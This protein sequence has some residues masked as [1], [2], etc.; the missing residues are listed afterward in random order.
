MKKKFKEILEKED[1]NK[2][3]KA[4]GF[5]FGNSKVLHSNIAKEEN[6]FMDLKSKFNKGDRSWLRWVMM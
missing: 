5:Y 1:L 4:K 3:S 2:K 6:V